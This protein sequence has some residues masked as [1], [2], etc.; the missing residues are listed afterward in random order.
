MFNK[1]QTQNN[2]DLFSINSLEQLKKY[3]NDNN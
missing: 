1:V 2:D 3:Y